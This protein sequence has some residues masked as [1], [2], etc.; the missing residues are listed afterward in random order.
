MKKNCHS[1]HQC[2]PNL[3]RNG[4]SCGRVAFQSL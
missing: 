4:I 1:S 3:G 2:H